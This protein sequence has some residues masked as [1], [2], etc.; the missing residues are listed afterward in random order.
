MTSDE[1]R[2]SAVKSVAV[3]CD[4]CP[5]APS[6]DTSHFARRRLLKSAVFSPP[7][8]ADPEPPDRRVYRSGTG[9]II[10]IS[11]H[12]VTIGHSGGERRFALTSDATA[13]RGEPLDPAALTPGD[14]AVIRITPSQSAIADRIWANIGRVCGVIVECDGERLVVTEGAMRRPKL[15]VISPLAGV[16]IKARLAT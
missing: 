2:V 9:T 7:P 3:C 1:R 14:D 11:P 8:I 15:V 12:Y 13:W 10:D 5:A 16:R 6:V 4:R